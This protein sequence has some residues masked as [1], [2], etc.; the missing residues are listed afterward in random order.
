MMIVAKGTTSKLIRVFIADTSWGDGRGLAGLAHNSGSLTAYYLREGAASAVA[1]TLA[2]M[3]VG[4]W[5]SGGFKEV[6]ATNMPGVYE[7]GIPDAA[8]ATGADSVIVQLKGATNMAVVTKEIQLSGVNLAATTID[9]NLTKIDGTAN[10]SATLNLTKLNI[11]N[12]GG[13]AVVASS[14]GS[15]GMG[16]NASGHGSGAGIKA[17]GGATG[18]GVW[19]LGGASGTAQNAG[20]R[21]SGQ[22]AG[23]GV[24]FNG[25][26]TNGV[27][28]VMEG[29]SDEATNGGVALII[30][31]NPSSVGTN[32]VMQITAAG[33]VANGVTIT[34]I[35]SG[36]GIKVTPGATGNG[37][38][39]IGGS[40]SGAAVSFAGTAG[41]A[42][43]LSLAG[44]GSGHGM[45]LIA[46][47]TGNAIRGIGGSTSGSAVSFSGTAGNADAVT[48]AGQGSAHALRLTGG[49]TGSGLVAIGGATSGA[50]ATFTGTAGNADAITLAG[51]GS[52]HGLSATGGATGSGINLVGGATSGAALVATASA[53]NANAVTLTGIGS[54][55]GL[56][57]TGG[58][59]GHGINAVGGATSGNGIQAFGGSGSGAGFRIVGGSTSG[60]GL[61]VTGGAT[62]NGITIAGGSTSGDG[63]NVSVTSGDEIDANLVGSI[64]GNITGNL[65]GSIGSVGAAGI[66]S[67]SFDT[68]AI[69][70]TAFN[71]QSKIIDAM[72]TYDTGTDY[73]S[74]GAATLVGELVRAV[75]AYNGG[76]QFHTAAAGS[77]TTLTLESGFRPGTDDAINGEML[78][79]VGGTGYGQSRPITDYVASTGVCT[80]PAWTITPDNTSVYC[81]LPRSNM[82]HIEGAALSGYN[83]TLKLKQ[84]DI[85][86]STDDAV[87][88][89][90]TGAGNGGLYV[91]SASSHAVE[92]NA[93]SGGGHGLLSAGG[94]TGGSGMRLLGT[95]ASSGI[96]VAGGPTGNGIEVVGGSTSG[97]GIKVTVTS[98]DEIEADIAGSIASL[99]TQAKADVNAEVVDALNVDTYAAMGGKSIVGAINIIGGM[100]AGKATISGSSAPF[101]ET[102]RN[103]ADSA[104][105][106]VVTV[107]ANG[108]RTASSIV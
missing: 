89:I 102:F 6:D 101:T 44:Q 7:L 62:G 49:A 106:A 87:K 103:L 83:A 37:I 19:A 99:G 22:A 28:A 105:V 11:V 12:S 78:F 60:H 2:T 20:I 94:G 17:T 58:L 30:R 35:G 93:G 14:T 76:L 86:N 31:K 70:P 24:F 43:A 80:V 96:Y 64:T 100:V 33:T 18:N 84:L 23:A 72:F 55:M 56:S 53:G 69:S 38:N 97:D 36:H 8:L 34:G 40:T 21:A 46:G 25:G 5:A 10:S 73:L 71:A 47:A 41:N 3:T 67:G 63:I 74:A 85:E 13:D 45:A 88:F 104:N 98:G 4:T 77:S 52:A 27:G 54:G 1:I 16:I 81:I 108:Q 107:D 48:L 32:D 51:Q 29:G 66:T 95:G 9:A 39:A 15:N 65:S 91:Q 57:T 75:S 59:T 92:F 90:G 42:S 79:I 26:A 82:T 61:H 68:D 50:A